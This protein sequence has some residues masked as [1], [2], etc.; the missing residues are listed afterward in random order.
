[1]SFYKYA[2]LL[3]LSA[4]VTAC[5][6]GGG[7]SPFSESG[8][9]PPPTGTDGGSTGGG[10]T[11]GGSADGGSTGGGSTGGDTEQPAANYSRYYQEI[12]LEPYNLPA[13]LHVDDSVVSALV[14]AYIGFGTLM[15]T[16]DARMGLQGYERL[17]PVAARDAAVQPGDLHPSYPCTAQGR[18]AIFDWQD[19]NADASYTSGEMVEFGFN[20]DNP[21][22]IENENCIPGFGEMLTSDGPTVAEPARQRFIRHDADTFDFT[23]EGTEL[24]IGENAYLGFTISGPL[25]RQNVRS[26]EPRLLEMIVTNAAPGAAAPGTFALQGVAGTMP[27]TV[28]IAG[29]QG[30]EASVIRSY[31]RD[32]EADDSTDLGRDELVFV[33]PNLDTHLELGGVDSALEGSYRL[34]SETGLATAYNH[35]AHLISG[36]FTVEGPQGAVYRFSLPAGSDTSNLWVEVDNEGDGTVDA[37]GLMSQ[38]LVINRLRLRN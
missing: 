31:K 36:G 18:V 23:L 20:R 8:S 2:L 11:G 29:G 32:T 33:V 10:S 7:T 28:S 25:V 3:S 22:T 5:G 13:G 30:V 16:L 26:S 12:G 15:A 4:A 1:M 14:P 24:D 27:V 35:A 17:L 6:G 9:N 21:D 38:Q 34:S 19:T 37:Q